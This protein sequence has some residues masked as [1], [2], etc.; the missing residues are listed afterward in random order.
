MACVVNALGL[1]YVVATHVINL[2]IVSLGSACVTR[3]S[4]NIYIIKKNQDFFCAIIIFCLW[5]IT[6]LS[7]GFFYHDL[8][9]EEGRIWIEC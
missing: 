7:F 5:V 6:E 1:G 4:N 3:A 8:S 9:G 2:I